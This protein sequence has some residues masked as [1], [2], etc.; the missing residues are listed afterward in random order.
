MEGMA[1]HPPSLRG[2]LLLDGGR[3]QGSWF[4]RTVVLV[5]QHDAE[6]AFGLVL[7]R[8]TGS[9][10]GDA[11]VGEISEPLAS[12]EL[13]IGGPVQPGALSYLRGEAILP[14]GSV[15]PGMDLGHSL[16]ELLQLAAAPSPDSRLLV[17]GGYSGWTAG[18]LDAE[19]ARDAWLVH[20]ATPDLVFDPDPATLWHRIVTGKGGLFRLLADSPDD[21]ASN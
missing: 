18:Q 9:R 5:C 13:R 6:G 20:P 10:I 15:M 2:Q 7:N 19:L 11:I 1:D 16:E 21:L 8:V 3:L 14:S 12:L 4:H 17:F